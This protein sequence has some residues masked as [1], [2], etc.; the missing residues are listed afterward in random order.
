M[1]C[2]TNFSLSCMA[3]VSCRRVGPFC[4]DDDKLKFIGRWQSRLPLRQEFT[5]ASR[6]KSP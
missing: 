6:D 3:K 1:K 2:S 4:L 5:A